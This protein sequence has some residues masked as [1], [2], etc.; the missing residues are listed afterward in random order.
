MIDGWRLGRK[1]G[2]FGLE[3]YFGASPE[4]VAIENGEFREWHF[5]LPPGWRDYNGASLEVVCAY[6]W[7]S[8]N[9]LAREAARS[10]PAAQWITVRYEDVFER[11]VEM[12]RDV[13]ARLGVPFDEQVQRRCASLANRQTSIVKGPPRRQKWR[14]HNPQAIERI[15]PMISPM[16]REMGYDPDH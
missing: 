4:P 7:L 1:D 16:M 14:E 2:G 3:R 6:Q 13:F 8:A 12:F 5:F 10:I 11:P 9:R 15:L